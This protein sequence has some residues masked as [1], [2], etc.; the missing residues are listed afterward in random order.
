M[1]LAFFTSPAGW[2]LA[3]LFRFEV[4]PNAKK[5]PPGVGGVIQRRN[6]MRVCTS[7]L[8]LTRSVP[9]EQFDG[10]DGV[11]T[12]RDEL[13]VIT[14]GGQQI[15]LMLAHER[16]NDLIQVALQDLIELVQAQID[17]MVGDTP[18][19]EVVGADAL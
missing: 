19:G 7:N 17:A 2:G 1:P 14:E 5:T 11:H 6:I 12:T 15:R 4:I 13:L 3:I 10:R 18:L 16:I 9:L 8:A